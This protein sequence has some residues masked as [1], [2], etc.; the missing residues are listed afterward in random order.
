MRSRELIISLVLSSFCIKVFAGSKICL[1]KEV[2]VYCEEEFEGLN[3]LNGSLYYKGQYYE[4]STRRAFSK[5][6]CRST[7]LKIQK[8]MGAGEFC[9][10]FE[11]KLSEKYL[12]IESVKGFKSSWSYFE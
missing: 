5:E 11:E 4:F 1:K 8:I 2:A 7:Q 9:M 6:W 10:K 12:T 3:S